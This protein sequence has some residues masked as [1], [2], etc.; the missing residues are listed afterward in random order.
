MPVI[1]PAHHSLF[2]GSRGEFLKK[3]ESYTFS[4]ANQMER[5][6]T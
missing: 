4:L 5:R 1:D 2:L 3:S 6:E